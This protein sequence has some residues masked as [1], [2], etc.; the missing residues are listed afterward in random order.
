MDVNIRQEIEK[1]H[2]QVYQLVKSAFEGMEFADGDEPELVVR[3]RKSEA[4][5][6]EL[7]LV[8]ESAGEILGHILFTKMK[9]GSHPSLALAPVAVLPA[10]HDMGIGGRLIQEG[11][12]LA[13]NLG[14]ASVIVVG[15]AAYYPRFGYRRASQWKITAPFD[16]PDEAFMAIEL[17]PGALDGVSGMIEYASEFFIKE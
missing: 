3:L 17:V 10:Y 6:P 12:R 2:V 1:D 16:I 7:S 5:I 11:H 8:A 9:I 14:Y 13:K 15:H 4:F